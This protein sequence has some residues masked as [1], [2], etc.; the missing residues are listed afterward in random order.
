MLPSIG[1]Q[2]A[3]HD[4]GTEQ[5]NFHGS[6]HNFMTIPLAY[7]LLSILFFLSECILKSHA[8]HLSVL[9]TLTQKLYPFSQLSVE[10]FKSYNINS[11]FPLPGSIPLL[12]YF[13]ISLTAEWIHSCVVPFSITAL[14]LR[15]GS[16]Q[17]E[18]SVTFDFP[19]PQLSC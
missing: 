18:T 9:Y 11:V 19:S 4:L 5:T 16:E 13:T 8:T 10:T 14:A 17:P 12:G 1:S 15:V 7:F 2:R 6:P 3:G